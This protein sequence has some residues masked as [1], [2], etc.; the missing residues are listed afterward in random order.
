MKIE[1]LKSVKDASL[2]GCRNSGGLFFLPSEA[3]LTECRILN[4][5]K[6]KK[7][8]GFDSRAGFFDCL[9]GAG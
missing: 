6:R 2:T 5:V 1:L 7:P 8:A 3:F 4:P 9:G